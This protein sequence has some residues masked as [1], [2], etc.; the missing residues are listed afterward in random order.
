MQQGLS[1]SVTVAIMRKPFKGLTVYFLAQYSLPSVKMGN[2]ELN[3]SRRCQIKPMG[4]PKRLEF[5]KGTLL[6][7]LED[8]PL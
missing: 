3:C 4:T 5:I 1:Q 6:L 7:V 2:G 8:I